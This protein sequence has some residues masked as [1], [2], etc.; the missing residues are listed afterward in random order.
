MEGGGKRAC[1]TAGGGGGG[2]ES[3]EAEAAQLSASEGITEW[4]VA[5][6][7][8]SRTPKN[9]DASSHA[10][11]NS[12]LAAAD[13]QAAAPNL[14]SDYNAAL[15]LFHL[16]QGAV[17]GFPS[18][19]P[20]HPIG[21]PAAGISTSMGGPVLDIA[22]GR[23][24]DGVLR[25]LSLEETSTAAQ[26]RALLQPAAFGPTAVQTLL[27]PNSVQSVLQIPQ[28]KLQTGVAALP[29]MVTLDTHGNSPFNPHSFG[30][31]NAVNVD[32]SHTG[33]DVP[34]RLDTKPDGSASR[35]HGPSV[36]R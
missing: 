17:H 35:S 16:Q 19:F 30:A 5:S 27:T 9:F 25:S 20:S 8:N 34:A 26:L 11:F 36:D 15:K 13:A 31:I 3:S 18:G 33:V 12:L 7:T 28:Y 23:G 6:F 22:A 10:G 21:S 14:L 1:S 29:S 4:Q 24:G 32:A 2:K